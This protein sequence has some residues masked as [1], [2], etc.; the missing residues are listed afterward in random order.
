[1]APRNIFL[2]AVVV[3]C[4]LTLPFAAFVAAQDDGGNSGGTY[5]GGTGGEGG[6]GGVACE[7]SSLPDYQY[8]VNLK[9]GSLILHWK[10]VNSTT[11]NFAAQALAG[12]AA[13]GWFAVGWSESSGKMVPGEAV[14][15]NLP[16]GKM[17][18]Y[19]LG[20]YALD[21]VVPTTNFSIGRAGSDAL[22]TKNSDKSFIM[23][24][25][26]SIN[27]G[28]V[29]VLLRGV[30]YMICAFSDGSQTL[31]PHPRTNLAFLSVDY[32]CPSSTGSSA[33]SSSQFNGSPSQPSSLPG[34]TWSVQLSKNAYVL[35]WAVN[36]DNTVS[37]AA[38]V[39]T[40]GYIGV[41]FSKDGKMSNSDA[42]IGNL[43]PGTLAN[44][45]AVGPY[46]MGGHDLES[47]QPTALWSVSNTS[48]TT[49]DGYTI[50]RFTR[51]MGMGQ[52]P[53]NAFG[54]NTIIWAYSPDGSTAL[55]DHRSNYGTATIDFVKG[56]VS[57]GHGSSTAAY[58]AHG[59]LLALAFAL[60]MPLAILLARLLLADRPH[61]ALLNPNSTAYIPTDANAYT[62]G[63][64]NGNASPAQQQQQPAKNLRPLGFQLHRGI[65]LLAL[66]VAVVGMIV[67]F[68]QVGSKGLSWKH[69]QVGLAAVILALLQGVVGFIRPDK[70]APSRFKWLVAHCVIGATTIA[71]AWAAIFLG[72][73]L[74]H[75]KFMENVTWCYWVS[76]VCVGIFGLAYLVL[77]IPDSILS[78]TTPKHSGNTGKGSAGV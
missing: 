54:P 64:G 36:R 39:A 48:V 1:M 13:A 32:S 68:V 55:A 26:R 65:Q 22:L 23:R 60:L 72:I 67:I 42:A 16:G 30:N 9:A 63:N 70:S 18:A 61:G 77:V 33:G 59:V 2:L 58:I 66:V 49:A 73:D 46:Y 38:Q 44:G 4:L 5:G 50:M 45:A 10:V 69:G 40:S 20:Y 28:S 78:L 8:S 71:L 75:T 53:I 41:G 37:M 25:S 24:F 43:P 35:H 27:D 17:G 19:S 29:K 47:V 62:N 31:T 7:P 76:G 34:Y 6:Y 57:A 51:S 12:P 21:A 52:V 56:T 74:Y 3:P 15:G 14:I 11:V